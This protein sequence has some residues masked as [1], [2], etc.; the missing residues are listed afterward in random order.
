[1]RE[2][3]AEAVAY[4]ISEGVGLDA[5]TASADYIQLYRGDAKTLAESLEAIRKVATRILSGLFSG[6]EKSAGREPGC[7]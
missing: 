5:T 3:E 6:T 7:D 1:M 4:V 2:L